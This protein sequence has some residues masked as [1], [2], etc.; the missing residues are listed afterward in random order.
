MDYVQVHPKQSLL[1]RIAMNLR[2]PLSGVCKAVRNCFLVIKP[3]IVLGNSISAAA[4]FALASRGGTDVA[5]LPATTLG[6]SLIVASAC[7]FNNCFDRTLDRRMAR[8]SRRVLARGIMPAGAA[9]AYGALLGISGATL[10]WTACNILCF[11]TAMAGFAIYV[12]LYTMGLKRNS[13][14]A[15]LVGSLAGAAPPVAGY[16]AARN[17]F[18]AGM[19]IVFLIFYLWQIPHWYAIAIFRR[20][21]FAAAGIPVVTG[22]AA[23]EKQI[24]FFIAAFMAATAMLTFGGYTGRLFLATS[25]ALNLGWLFLALSGCKAPDKRLWGGKLLVISLLNITI[26]SIMMAL[27]R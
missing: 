17:G 5:G 25:V 4:G 27:H 12:F 14:R 26:L 2:N 19:A 15:F 13:V 18:D 23:A 22:E 21:D 7:V 9:V 11:A 10:L 8:T 16:C 20:D 3:G 24:A 6:I 1:I